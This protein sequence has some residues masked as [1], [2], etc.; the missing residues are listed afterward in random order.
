MNPFL[1]YEAAIPLIIAEQPSQIM[2]HREV[3]PDSFS[4]PVPHIA[5]PYTVRIEP[6]KQG[7]NEVFDEKGT[8][9]KILF[10]M[11]GY[12]LPRMLQV[13]GKL[14]PLFL[15]DDTITDH[16]GNK[17][18][19]RSPQFCRGKVVQVTLELRA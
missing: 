19:V 11:V 7:A 3:R 1:S 14:A 10:T 16:E 6:I 15:P 12:N 8:V 9:A 18:K 17:Y 2:R 5:G 13:N 4:N